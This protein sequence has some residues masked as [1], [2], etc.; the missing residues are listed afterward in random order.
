MVDLNL[1]LL[2]VQ[3]SCMQGLQSA[4]NFAITCTEQL[5][6]VFLAALFNG[7]LGFLCQARH[8]HSFLLTCQSCVAIIT[9]EM[10]VMSRSHVHSWI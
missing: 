3:G 4:L 5:Q 9:T 1:W 7:L 8:F 2:V 6:Q 10:V